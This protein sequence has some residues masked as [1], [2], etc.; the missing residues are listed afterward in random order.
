MGDPASNAQQRAIVALGGNEGDVADTF[1]RTIADLIEHPEIDVVSRSRNFTTP[2]V[3]SAAGAS[4][5]NAAVLLDTS[6]RPLE[7]LDELQRVENHRGR[8][9]SVR[10]GPRT[11][12]L[13][14]ICHSDAVIESERLTLPHPACWYRRFVLDPVAEIAGD[15][16]HPVL[17]VTFDELRNRLLERPLRVGIAQESASLL[18]TPDLRTDFPEVEWT[19]ADSEADRHGCAITLTRTIPAPHFAIELATDDAIQSARDAIRAALGES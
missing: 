19:N 16:V 17:N 8:V 14:V 13:D 5:L 6:L 10:W 4:F 12:D 9:R 15:F 7:L 1:D 2:A 11:L 18:P 3:G